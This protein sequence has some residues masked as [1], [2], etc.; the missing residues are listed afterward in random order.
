MTQGGIVSPLLSN[1]VLHDLD[2]FIARLKAKIDK[3][4]HRRISK[5]YS[6]LKARRRSLLSKK[7][8]TYEEHTKP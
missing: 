4:K 3:G 7:D 1:I 8:Y 2:M 6:K 5:D